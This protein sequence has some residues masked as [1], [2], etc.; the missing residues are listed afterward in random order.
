MVKSLNEKKSKRGKMEIVLAPS[1]KHVWALLSLSFSSQHRHGCWIRE[2]NLWRE[3][4]NSF[5]NKQQSSKARMWNCSSARPPN[6]SQ[7]TFL[8][9]CLHLTCFNIF[10]VISFALFL[11]FLKALC[12]DE[13]DCAGLNGFSEDLELKV[14]GL[15]CDLG[16]EVCW[17]CWS[18]REM[19]WGDAGLRW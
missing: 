19:G 1:T 2:G 9:K 14:C 15:D 17:V 3:D 18:K 16:R 13:A 7:I 6:S 4:E 5:I 8:R 12:M 11:L 10:V